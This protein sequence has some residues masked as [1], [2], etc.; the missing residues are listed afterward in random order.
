MIVFAIVIFLAFLAFVFFV[1]LIW[2]FETFQGSDSMTEYSN[3]LDPAFFSD[4]PLYHLQ[5]QCS[6]NST[7]NVTIQIASTAVPAGIIHIL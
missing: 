5:P 7:L 4:R 3:F 6:A 1:L 2:I